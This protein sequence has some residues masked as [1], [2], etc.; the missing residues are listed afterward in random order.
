MDALVFPSEEWVAAWTSQC[1]QSS[2]YLSAARGWDGVVTLRISPDGDHR[3]RPL[4][5]QLTAQ[6]GSWTSHQFGADPALADNPSFL[7]TAPYRTW[8]QLVR[9]EIDPVRAIMR[10]TVRVQGRLSELLTWSGSLRV[11]T[12]LAGTVETAFE[13]EDRRA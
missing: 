12:E 8:K 3:E 10:G 4:Y 1:N 13:D 6:D 2:A 7:L 9:Q 5:V 11:M